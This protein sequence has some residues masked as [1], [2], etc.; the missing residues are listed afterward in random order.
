MSQDPQADAVAKK[1]V[2]YTMPG[3]DAVTVRRDEPYLGADGGALPMDLYYPPDSTSGAPTPAVIFV[4]GYPDA[5]ARQRLGRP[6]KEMGSYVSWAELAAASGLAAVTY[7]NS[8]PATDVH[9]VLRHLRQNAASLGIDENRLGIWACSGNAP[10]ALS[11]V[12]QDAHEYLK[13]AVLCYALT[14]DLD[15]STG[16]AD[17]ASHWGFANPCGGKSVDDLPRDVPLFIA[18]AG[19]DQMPG[20]NSALDRFLAKAVACNLPVTFVNH[21]EAPHAFDLFHDSDTSREIIRGLLGFMRFHLL[22]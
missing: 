11:V 7:T 13:C 9:A 21:S 2:V 14:L 10:N 3:T 1:R 12:M 5:G 16:I 20:L 4:T 22:G 8:D 15:G 19:Q 17:A 6:L 18:R